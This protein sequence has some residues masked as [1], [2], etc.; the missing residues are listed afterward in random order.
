[1]T[2]YALTVKVND[3]DVTSFI[4]Y[5]TY[6]HEDYA[7]Q[8]STF[9][10]VIENPTGVTPSKGHSVVVIAKNVTNAPIIFQGNIVTMRE[11]KRDNG[12]VKQYHLDCAD[13]KHRMQNTVMQTNNLSGSDATILGN[14]LSNA[15]PDLSDLLDF[16]TDVTSFANDLDLP[17][18]ENLF[19]ALNDLAD[20]SGGA[21]WRLENPDSASPT[22]THSVDF[23]GGDSYTSGG[24]GVSPS[25]GA[26]GN[27]GN[28]LNATWTISAS[29]E[30]IYIDID[31]GSEET[32]TNIN[33][34]MWV[35]QSSCKAFFMLDPPDANINPASV[36]HTG[37]TILTA[38]AS[39]WLNAD[40]TDPFGT[41]VA[42]DYG[43]G[44]NGA[45]NVLPA[46]AQVIRVG[47]YRTATGSSEMR[48]DNI[49]VTY[50]DSK[51]KLQWDDE[52][53][54]ADFD[55]DVGGLDDEFAFDIDLEI[56]DFDDFNSITVN[57]FDEQA[58]EWIYDSHG[59]QI[60]HNL[61]APIRDYTIYKNTG[62]DASPTWTEQSH[63][64]YGQDELGSVD[65][66]Y[67]DNHQWLLFNTAPADLKKSVRVTGK[68]LIPI[69]VRVNDVESGAAIYATSLSRPDITNV[70]TAVAVG[71][72]NLNKR[73]SITRLNFKT[74]NWGLKAGQNMTVADSNRGLS[75]T[76]TIQKIS[77]TWL[78]GT[79]A[80]FEVECGPDEG[81]NI[82]MT[83]A[84]NDKRSRA[85]ARPKVGTTLEVSFL[86]DENDNI[87]TDAN[88]AWLY[89]V[90]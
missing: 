27:T 3:V 59:S 54:A 81:S 14:L 28:C 10:M 44:N 34:D 77:T 37:E 82:A 55:I 11:T 47:V 7:R 33:L 13:Y 4:K 25:V 65:V 26:G 12:V 90:G 18:P 9:K 74:Y 19:D 71:L 73:N 60:Q 80:L 43:F 66:V 35:G 40:D 16:D 70:D 2:D 32:I 68:I 49:V 64:I 61:E 89:E 75:E 38:D 20:L 84:N 8:V 63:G 30:G 58:F 45:N 5:D 72:S 51:T 52:P 17:V 78:G 50:G 57:A 53:D 21:E 83:I 39:T 22:A 87:L 76:L 69:S 1:M 24:D 15:Y 31:L 85:N 29:G 23:D 6:A 42:G 56:G 46:S 79:R 48:I 36:Y 62:T 41:A 88:G 86:T 67:D